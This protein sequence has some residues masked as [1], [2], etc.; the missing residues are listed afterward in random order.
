MK[1][2]SPQCPLLR[3]SKIQ[4]GGISTPAKYLMQPD[5][6]QVVGSG[7]I[8]RQYLALNYLKIN[9]LADWKQSNNDEDLETYGSG[10]SSY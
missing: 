7:G 10:W 8:I 9:F 2:Y 3:D 6:T 4:V 5:K 1:L